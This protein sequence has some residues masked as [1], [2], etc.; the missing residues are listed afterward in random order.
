MPPCHPSPTGSRRPKVR[1][2]VDDRLSTGAAI[3]IAPKQSH[4]LLHVMRLG[5][6]DMLRLFNGRDGDWLARV[7]S[8]SRDAC[9]VQCERCVAEQRPELGPWLL[10]AP[11]K[12]A[13]LDVLAEKATEL[14]VERLVPL[15][16]RNTAV[17]RVNIERLRAQVIEAAE[18]CGRQTIPVVCALEPIGTV[19]AGWPPGRSLLFL[20]E[21]GRGQPIADALCTGKAVDAPTGVLVGP[22]GGFEVEEAEALRKLPFVQPVHLGPRILRAETAAIAVLACWQALVGDWRLPEPPET[23]D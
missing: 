19:L 1:L 8:A 7:A 6:G 3:P 9:T 23:G 5:V 13:A 12:K 4:Y 21:R 15:R 17:D 20:D 16:T 2:C 10:F 14:G 11:L 22:E 18:Q